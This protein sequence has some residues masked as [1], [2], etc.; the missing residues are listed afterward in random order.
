METYFSINLKDA[1]SCNKKEL[2]KFLKSKFG[3]FSNKLCYGIHN[4]VETEKWYIG[5]TVNGVQQRFWRTWNTAHFKCIENGIHE[6]INESN[7]DK[8]ELVILFY[9]ESMKM[10]KSQLRWKETEYITKYDSYNLGYNK[11]PIAQAGFYGKKH[12]DDE[13][14]K[15]IR[16]LNETNKDP[17]VSK[18][19]SNGLK[20]AWSRPEYREKC[21]GKKV[22]YSCSAKSVFMIKDEQVNE[23]KSLYPDL[24][25]GKPT[26]CNE[27]KK[28]HSYEWWND[29]KWNKNL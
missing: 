20:S 1:Y 12:S 17:E 7:I 24:N 26:M 6:F 8:Y 14:R 25:K 23:Y 27:Y 22:W 29:P 11:I 5:S 15:I 19:R 13:K 3:E 21:T 16:S 18:R 4:L 9:D 2:D 10:T 28:N